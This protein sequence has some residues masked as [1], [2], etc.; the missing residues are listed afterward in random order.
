MRLVAICA[1]FNPF[2][3]ARRERA[4]ELFRRGM[5]Q[6]GVRV[7]CVEQVF[8]GVRRASC[9]GDIAIEGGA[10]MWQKECLLQIGV[11]RAISEGYDQLLLCD[12]DIVFETPEAFERIEE[13]FGRYELFQP[14]ESV[15]LEYSDGDV[16]RQ[17]ALSIDLPR[18]YGSGHPGSCWA[19]TASFLEKVRLYPF[20]ILGGG[21]VVLTHLTS[22]VVERRPESPRFVDLCVHIGTQVLYPTLIESL[23][24]WGRQFGTSRFRVGHTPGVR[25]R[26]MNHGPYARRR[27]LD[28]YR[29]WQCSASAPRPV[30]DLRVGPAGLLEWVAPREE[31]T[32]AIEAYFSSREEDAGS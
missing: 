32:R 1:F 23:V 24:E 17:S 30:V 8:A 7:L 20:A 11:D 12:A 5:E 22:A 10:L 6:A 3:S 15:V 16:V 2:G 13:S 14:F 4:F 25:L 9:T 18:P 31:W 28:R 21:D 26:S 29:A 27:Y 19:V